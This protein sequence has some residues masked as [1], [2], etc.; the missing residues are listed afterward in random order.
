LGWRVSVE[1]ATI[2]ADQYRWLK[3]DDNACLFAK[4]LAAKPANETRWQNLVYRGKV[5]PD[6]FGPDLHGTLSDL[7][8]TG[9]Q[10]ASCIFPELESPGEITE[11][12]GV[13][14]LDAAHWTCV[15][16]LCPPELPRSTFL[17]GLRWL[18][19][20][21]YR[22]LVVG[23]A[24][25][26]TMPRTRQT[27]HT[28][29]TL[30]L[31]GPGSSMGIFLGDPEEA[32]TRK[33]VDG[34]IAVHLADVPP[35]IENKDHVLKIRKRMAERMESILDGDPMAAAANPFLT[36]SLPQSMRERLA[37]CLPDQSSW[38]PLPVL[39]QPQDC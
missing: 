33:K 12:L 28:A 4:F 37:H 14:C 30:R 16:Y 27:P 7:K 18:M 20:G 26:P 15:P 2:I 22:D 19:P 13:L 34:R 10:V 39:G 9:Q 31:G 8:A 23:F 25:I 6:S 17:I 38:K 11:L 35:L 5:F 36:F 21:E 29:L 24:R 1:E 3:S 32:R